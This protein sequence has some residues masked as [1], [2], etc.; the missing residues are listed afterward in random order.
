MRRKKILAFA[1]SVCMVMAPVASVNAG[2]IPD[3]GVP[4][5]SGTAESE[6]GGGYRF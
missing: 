5:Q 6:L 1:L 3:I 2:S 4:S